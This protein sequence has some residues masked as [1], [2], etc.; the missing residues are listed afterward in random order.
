M[1]PARNFY[2]YRI[3]KHSQTKKQQYS[4]RLSITKDFL[5]QEKKRNVWKLQFT[6]SNAIS[7]RY[8]AKTKTVKEHCNSLKSRSKKQQYS[9]KL[10][11]VKAATIKRLAVEENLSLHDVLATIGKTNRCSNRRILNTKRRP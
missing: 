11:T 2:T 3:R 4:L 7:V 8:V 1:V 5:E 10:L 9:I 6:T